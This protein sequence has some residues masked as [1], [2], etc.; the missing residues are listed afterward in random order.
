M[1]E[2]FAGP[3]SADLVP[4]STRV[5]ER[6]A[7]TPARD[8]RPEIELRR[9]LHARGLRYRI[10]AA[11]VPGVR[12]RVDIVFRAARVAVLVDGCFW[13][14]CPQHGTSPKRNA[15]F[16]RQKIET[17]RRRDADTDA[18]LAAAGWIV[19]RVWEHEDLLAAAERVAEAVELGRSRATSAGGPKRTRG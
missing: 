19:V 14:G 7:G 12:R 2:T 8:T 11:V 9:L 10:D 15:D 13:H 4:S 17:N 1:N 6:L 5:S 18:R 3:S 16:W